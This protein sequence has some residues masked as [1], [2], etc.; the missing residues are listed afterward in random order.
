MN[1]FDWFAGEI[2]RRMR[3]G[4]QQD[5]EADCVREYGSHNMGSPILDVRHDSP[6]DPHEEL[7]E[8]VRCGARE[9]AEG[10]RCRCKEEAKRY[11]EQMD[12][13]ESE[14]K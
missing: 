3:A 11:W 12:L 9:W 13:D 5:R 1:T 7:R 6:E 10:G 2:E 14:G 4:E 8:C